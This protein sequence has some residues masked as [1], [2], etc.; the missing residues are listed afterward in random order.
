MTPEEVVVEWVQENKINAGAVEKLFEEGFT[1]LEALKLLDEEDLS[2]SKIPR[3]QKKLI[4]SCVRALNGGTTLGSEVKHQM[5]DATGVTQTNS[6][7]EVRARSTEGTQTTS[8]QS[9]TSSV[10]YDQENGGA[11]STQSTAD[12]QGLLNQLVRGQM[13]VQNGL[14]GDLSA[15]QTPGIN[16]SSGSLLA[17]GANIAQTPVNHSWKDLQIYLSSA[18]NSKS[19]STHYDIMDFVSGDVEEEIIVGGTGAHQVVLKSGPKKPRKVT[20]AQWTI[21]NLAILY[22]LHQESKLTGEAILDYLSYTTKICQFSYPSAS[23]IQTITYISFMTH[24]HL[25][26]RKIR[27]NPSI[28]SGHSFR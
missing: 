24:L 8:N 7:N 5:E 17:G 25:C 2:K 27:L 15:I 9:T 18:A 23:G 3:G 28:Y 10:S 11:Q 20:L 13:Q 16:G 12:V 21:A 19:A 14:A 26:L 6:T 4:L 1:S 22:K